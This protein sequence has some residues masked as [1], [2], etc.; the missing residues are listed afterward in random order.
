MEE[1]EE[2]ERLQ[3]EKREEEEFVRVP[4]DTAAVT[5]YDLKTSAAGET[6]QGDA[7]GKKDK[8]KKR[9]NKKVND[10]DDVNEFTQNQSS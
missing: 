8:K 9:K 1:E 7:D 3:K 5:Q 2:E 4:E 6:T 10:N